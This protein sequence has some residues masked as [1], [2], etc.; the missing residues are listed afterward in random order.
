MNIYFAASISS[1]RQRAEIYPFII[2]DLRRYGRVV[3]EFVADQKMTKMGNRELTPEQVYQGDIAL[4]DSS[5]VVV[6]E[7]TVP[8][9]GVGV[10]IAY[11]GHHG[12]PVLALY[13][14]APGRRLSAM[15]AGDHNVTVAEYQTNKQLLAAIKRFFAKLPPADPDR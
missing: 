5:Q 11:A 3:S 13:Q 1:G 8:S 6:A 4:I 10:E 7:V 9:S 12:K 15:I 2:Q 14:P